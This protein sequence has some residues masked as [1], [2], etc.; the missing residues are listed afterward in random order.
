MRKA[1]SLIA[2]V[3]LLASLASAAPTCFDSD[4]R[5]QQ[6]FTHAGR[7][8]PLTKPHDDGG[9]IFIPPSR[10]RKNFD[11]DDMMEKLIQ[12][13]MQTTY[14]HADYMASLKAQVC[15]KNESG[16]FI[17]QCQLEILSRPDIRVIPTK[18]ISKDILCSTAT[19]SIA[20]E[21]TVSISTTHSVEVSLAITAGAKPF[22]IGMEFTVTTSYG[23]SNT[24]EQSTALSYSFDLVRGDTGYIGIVN[25][26]VSAQVRVSGCRCDNFLCEIQCSSSGPTMTETGHHEAVILQNGKPRGYVSFVYTS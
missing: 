4:A 7:R 10:S 23:F 20:L 14:S 26:Q 5:Q 11:L 25:A 13:E 1:L 12:T 16:T 22:G 2:V 9:I 19:C 3:G 15:G 24:A 18:S 8:E 21:E 17:A 6:V